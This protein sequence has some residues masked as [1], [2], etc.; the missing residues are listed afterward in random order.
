MAPLL[1][2]PQL[3]FFDQV[4]DTEEGNPQL[5]SNHETVSI[6]IKDKSIIRASTDVTMMSTIES[7][8][9]TVDYHRDI[10]YFCKKMDVKSDELFI[11]SDSIT[12][13]LIDEIQLFWN[14]ADLYKENQLIHKLQFPILLFFRKNQ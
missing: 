9:Y 1:E 7:G 10:G 5:E 6:W 14:K 11:F 13:K 8:V 3:I 2:Q 4:L 12:Q